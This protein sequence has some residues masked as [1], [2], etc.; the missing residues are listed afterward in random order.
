MCDWL[1]ISKLKAAMVVSSRK[2]C[3]L[4]DTHGILRRPKLV[5]CRKPGARAS[6]QDES[7]GSY[8]LVHWIRPPLLAQGLERLLRIVPSSRRSQ[9]LRWSPRPWVVR[10]NRRGIVENRIDDAPRFFY[11]VL[12]GKA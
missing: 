9:R 10:V 7:R 11:I 5:N 3:Q 8:G 2:G 4:R 12:P 1:L 6:T